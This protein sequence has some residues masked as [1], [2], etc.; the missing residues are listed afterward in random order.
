M[1]RRVSIRLLMCGAIAAP[2]APALVFAVNCQPSFISPAICNPAH[3][4]APAQHPSGGDCELDSMDICSPTPNTR[5]VDRFA[6]AVA[7]ACQIKINEANPTGC[8][9]DFG[10]TVVD[11]PKYLAACSDASG[12]CQCVYTRDTQT[13]PTQVQVCECNEQPL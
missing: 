11:L 2:A 8:T 13:T 4:V 9:L 1:L 10:V 6:T 7:G 12:T 3:A 5:C